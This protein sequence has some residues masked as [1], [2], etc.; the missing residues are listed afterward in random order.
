MSNFF[1]IYSWVWMHVFFMC[2]ILCACSKP[3]EVLDAGSVGDW[4]DG[5]FVVNEGGFN[6]QNA[7]L[8]WYDRKSGVY[9]DKVYS[10][11]NESDLGDI[12]QSLNITPDV[13]LLV[14]NNSDK[15][16]VVD[17]QSLK[18]K[19][20]LPSIK[21]PRYILPIDDAITYISSLTEKF[22][23]IWDYKANEL[24]GR[25]SFPGWSEHMLRYEDWVIVSSP[26]FYLGDPTEHLYVIDARSHRLVD[27]I[28]VL[29]SPESMVMDKEGYLWVYCQ[30]H[31]NSDLKGGLAR[32]DISKGKMIDSILFKE[33]SPGFATS[34]NINPKK[35]SLYFLRRDVF[36]MSTSD[37]KLPEKPV[38]EANGRTFYALGIAPTGQIWTGDAV[39]FVQNGVVSIYSQKG[40]LIKEFR[41]GVNPSEFYFR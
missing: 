37:N 17:R 8:G 26:S 21:S 6:H 4:E 2:I 19:Y 35:D 18:N 1:P 20:T 10:K 23:T 41:V 30:G 15:V 39:D 14:V 28:R 16:E 27:S 11:V 29:T 40:K 24:I 32:V 38:V 9:L 5:V 13:I 25:I 7:S 36:A 22:I 31:F 33:V 34:L 3:D 12:F